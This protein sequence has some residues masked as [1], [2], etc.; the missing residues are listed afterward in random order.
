[1]GSIQEVRDHHGRRYR[2]GE[3]PRELM[4]RS[5]AWILLLCWSPML[6]VGAGQYA[7]GAMIPALVAGREWQLGEFF[8]PLAA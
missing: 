1:M 2:L 5:R 8:W 7:Y 4:G 3:Q 6:L